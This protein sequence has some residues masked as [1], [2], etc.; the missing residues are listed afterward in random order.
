[1]PF[2]A[3]NKKEEQPEFKFDAGHEDHENDDDLLERDETGGNPFH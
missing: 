2:I 1:M 3:D